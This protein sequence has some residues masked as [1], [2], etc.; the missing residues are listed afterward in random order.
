MTTVISDP[1]EIFIAIRIP[2]P[3][4]ESWSAQVMNKYYQDSF[5]DIIDMA[6]LDITTGNMGPYI[7]HFLDVLQENQDA[8]YAKYILSIIED[9]GYSIQFVTDLYFGSTNEFVIFQL[10]YT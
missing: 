1:D 8:P 4:W 7:D 5:F 3:H 6:Y 2:E 10:S 9:H